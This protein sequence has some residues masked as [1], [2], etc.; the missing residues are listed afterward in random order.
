[1][2]IHEIDVVVCIV[3]RLHHIKREKMKTFEHLN[4]LTLAYVG[5]AIYEIYVRE[6]LVRMG[7][8]KP[9]NLHKL[10]T[11]YVS[12]KAQAMVMQVMLDNAFLTEKEVEIYKRG[13]NTKSATSAKNTDILTYRVATG[14]EAVLGYLHLEKQTDRLEEI[15]TFCFGYIGEKNAK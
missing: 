2:K 12:A 11:Q 1:M 6:Y 5:D 4:G 14:F 8:A 9:N 13:R 10:S 3:K 15:I 7:I